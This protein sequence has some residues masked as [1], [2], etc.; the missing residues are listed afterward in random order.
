MN[1]VRVNKV[2]ARKYSGITVSNEEIE[3]AAVLAK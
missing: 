2:N 3:M 1:V